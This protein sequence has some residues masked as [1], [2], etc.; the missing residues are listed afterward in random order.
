MTLGIRANRDCYCIISHIG[1]NGGSRLIFPNRGDTDNY[2]KKDETRALFEGPARVR[3]HEP[4]GQEQLLVTV[5]SAQFK[6]LEKAM[7]SPAAAGSFDDAASKARGLTAEVL[8]A[9]DTE[10]RT[11][12]MAFSI[13]PLCHTDFEFGDPARALAEAAEDARQ[14]GGSFEGDNSEGFYVIDGGRA[15]YKVNGNVITLITRLP[16]EAASRP[17]ARGMAAPLQ[18]DLAIA[19]AS[20]PGQ[21]ASTGE[22]IKQA[23]GVFAGDIRGGNFAVRKPVEIA[24]NY[25]VA[26]E[27]VTVLIT[28]YPSLFAGAIKSKIRE[29]FS[30]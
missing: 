23:G 30:E 22:K 10:Y 28:K 26:G 14:R 24:G 27:R 4:F 20:M 12:S 18:I 1:A 7:I 29:Y 21:I 25:R 16:P 11:K 2:L 3:L 8:P 19:R 17:L 5:S 9:G 6:D 13:L 15:S